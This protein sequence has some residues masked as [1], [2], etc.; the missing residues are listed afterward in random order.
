M[1]SDFEAALVAGDI[2]ALR[3]SPKADLHNHIIGG[4]NRDDVREKTGVDVA[5]LDYV[6]KSMDEMHEW[7]GKHMGDAFKGPLGR[8]I[9]IETAFMQAKLDGV[10]RLDGG[11]DVWAMTLWENRDV[12][13][14]TETMKEIHARVAPEIEWTPQMGLSRHCPIQYL[15][16]WSAP[17]LELDF[18]QTVDLYADEFAQ[19]ISVFK[20]VYRAAKAKG[21]R[22]RAHAGEWGTADDVWQAVEEL[23]LDEV[24]HGI[25][26]ASS[27]QVMRFLADN[28]IRLNICPTSNIMLGRVES[29]AAHPI[30]QLF[31]AGIIVTVNTDD[32][33]MFGIGVTDEYLSLYRAGVFTPAELDQIRRNGLTDQP[34]RA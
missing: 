24:Q 15:M 22:L 34:L 19:P 6:L 20:P 4:G 7:N 25:A 1:T 3:A 13:R 14:L 27:P 17:F 9:G 29:M 23:E 21:L 31:D 8:M 10:T 32:A 12:T 26:A 18:Y 28:R 30:R 16:E 33:L 11:E 5:P 2:A